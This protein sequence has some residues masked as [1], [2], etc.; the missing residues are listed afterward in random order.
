MKINKTLIFILT[1]VDTQHKINAMI[2]RKQI[3]KMLG[4]TE[5]YLSMLLLP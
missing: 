3:A 4:I 5:A 1:S 2:N